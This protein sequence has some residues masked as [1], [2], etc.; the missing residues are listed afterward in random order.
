[1]AER[2]M[3]FGNNIGTHEGNVDRSTTT[4]IE[5][6]VTDLPT[7]PNK[8]GP[9]FSGPTLYAKLVTGEQSRKSM[10]FRTLF[11]PAGNGADVAISLE[12]VRA[13][14]ERVTNTVYGFFWLNGWLIPSKDGMDAR[15]ENGPCVYVTSF[16]GDGLNV[17][18]T[19]LGTPLMLDSYTY[20][21]CMQSWGRSSYARVMIEL[22][23]DLELKDTI[24]VA[25]PKLVSEGFYMCT[26]R[27][28]YWWKCHRCSSCKV[29]GHV[30]DECPNNIASDVVKLEES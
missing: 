8:S 22:R 3:V 9:S 16:N 4:P 25:M 2:V 19:K 27:V 23:A 13:N 21:I 20:N 12:S 14:S 15:I 10:T 29:F 28:E 11:A 30:L 18:S 17:I 1:M 26:I 7:D 24:M 6:I 5:G